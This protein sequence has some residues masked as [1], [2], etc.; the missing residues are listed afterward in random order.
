MPARRQAGPKPGGRGRNHGE[1]RRPK[2]PR[3]SRPRQH[4]ARGEPARAPRTRRRSDR[5]T[6]RAWRS[7]RAPTTSSARSARA[8]A[9]DPAELAEASGARRR[10]GSANSRRTGSSCGR[11]RPEAPPAYD[12]DASPSC[13]A[14]RR[15]SRHGIEARHLRMYRHLRGAR[16]AAVRPGAPGVL[17]QRNPAARAR[18]RWTSRT[19][20]PT[21]AA[22]SASP[23][24]GRARAASPTDRA[25]DRRPRL[26]TSSTGRS[27]P[28][29]PRAWAGRSPRPPRRRRA[30]RV[31]KG[32]LLFL[33]DL[34]RAL[35][36]RGRRRRLPRDLAYVPDTELSGSSRTSTSTSRAATSSWSRTS[37]TPASRPAYLLRQ[38]ASGARDASTSAPCS[39]ARPASS[40]STSVTTGEAIPDLFVRLRHASAELYRNLTLV[41]EADRWVAHAEP[42]AYA[43][44]ARGPGRR[45]GPTGK[46]PGP[47]V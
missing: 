5:H 41:D 12:E 3:R 27:S 37:S 13:A 36:G 40:R 1:A 39:T 31:L 29:S 6:G 47:T 18:P 24:A 25:G 43:R 9:C 46:S 19:S 35:R 26:P 23:L 11:G 33:S 21:A 15:A 30:R 10:G 32:A 2:A 38:P 28:R 14:R 44:A 20:P 4:A 17:R 16:G 34:A 22:W 45:A 8:T 7:T 42:G